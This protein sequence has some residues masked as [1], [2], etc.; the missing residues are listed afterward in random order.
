MH[1]AHPVSAHC[2]HRVKGMA[3]DVRR[4]DDRRK[5][6]VTRASIRHC[7]RELMSQLPFLGRWT[8]DRTSHREN[9][10]LGNRDLYWQ[11]PCRPAVE[12]HDDR[13]ALRV[14]RIRMQLKDLRKCSLVTHR[15]D[16]V[17]TIL[18]NLLGD[19]SVVDGVAIVK[20]IHIPG[21]T[22]LEGGLAVWPNRKHGALSAQVLVRCSAGNDKLHPQRCIEGSVVD[23]D[24]IQLLKLDFPQH[25]SHIAAAIR[26]AL[27]GHDGTAD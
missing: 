5:Y 13:Q 8:V 23:V 24:A 2:S 16:Q 11:R 21:G 20:L 22:R 27:D 4:E 1:R 15:H 7:H 9:A 18:H 25:E 14:E 3:S 26:S 10:F 17:V 12:V 19:D 6:P